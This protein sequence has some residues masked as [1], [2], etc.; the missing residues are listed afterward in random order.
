[1]VPCRARLGAAD[2]SC[3]TRS[4]ARRARRP[5]PAVERP[6]RGGRPARAG[7]RAHLARPRFVPTLRG[8]M[9]YCVIPR[10]LEAELFDKMVEDYKD[11]PK[12][13]VIVDRRTGPDRR[14][15][16]SY[17]GKRLLRARRRKRVPGTFPPTEAPD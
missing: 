1:P 7:Y 6:R 10:E 17:G 5:L 15:G 13:T 2:P 4:R 9:I 16:K 3:R 11:T 14:S 12:V 8:A